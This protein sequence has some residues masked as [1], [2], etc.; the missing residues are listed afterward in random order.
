MRLA[1]HQKGVA[2][3]EVAIAIFIM[4]VGLLGLA[5]LQF[6]SLRNMEVSLKTNQANT[7]LHEL[8]EAMWHHKGVVSQFEREG[9]IEGVQDPGC[10]I[11][12]SAEEAA[13]FMIKTIEN[14]MYDNFESPS[15]NITS[16]PLTTYTITEPITDENGSPVF[17]QDGTVSTREVPY[18]VKV[19]TLQLTWQESGNFFTKSND[20]EAKQH[21]LKVV[22]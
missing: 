4:A 19:Y 13:T 15:L 5:S 11:Q 20:V 17:N 6:M 14:R 21:S 7:Y 10:P 8:A 1:K 3:L 22:L 16:E 9:L 18:Q 2:L 12:C